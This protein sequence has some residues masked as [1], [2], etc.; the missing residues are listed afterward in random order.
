MPS[1]GV[2]SVLSRRVLFWGDLVFVRPRKD[3]PYFWAQWLIARRHALCDAASFSVELSPL[4]RWWSFWPSPSSPPI[5]RTPRFLEQRFR[6]P[7]RTRLA[8]RSPERRRPSRTRR[9][10]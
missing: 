9:P 8:P 2:L 7:S 3:P 4:F 1:G 5:M 10:V 6:A